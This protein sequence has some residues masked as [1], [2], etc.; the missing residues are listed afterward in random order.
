M[1]DED[2]VHEEYLRGITH[3]L[4]WFL[5]QRL[6]DSIERDRKAKAEAIAAR[7]LGKKR[8]VRCPDCGGATP[9]YCD[10]CEGEGEVIYA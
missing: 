8:K 7:L 2:A 3:G 5:A 1:P 9:A 6:L 4:P 10:T